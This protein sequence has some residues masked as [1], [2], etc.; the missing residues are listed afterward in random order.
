MDARYFGA[1]RQILFARLAEEFSGTFLVAERGGRL[2]GLIVGNPSGASCEIGPWVVEPG[3]GRIAE[4]LYRSLIHSA[5]DSKAAFSG[6]PRNPALQ[7]LVHETRFKD[8]L[9]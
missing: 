1:N 4:H 3:S 2:S 6:P 7:G 8:V 9:C 5:R